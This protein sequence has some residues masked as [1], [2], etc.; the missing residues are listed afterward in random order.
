M[1]MVSNGVK[2]PKVQHLWEQH[3]CDPKN[4]LL[5]P[6]LKRLAEQER[7]EQFL[8]STSHI[9][10]KV[11]DWKWSAHNYWPLKVHYNSYNLEWYP[12]QCPAQ[13]LEMPHRQS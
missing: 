8:S 4:D 9:T 5:D 6:N 11:G 2:Q 12:I 1:L 3:L 13:S 10:F 7:C